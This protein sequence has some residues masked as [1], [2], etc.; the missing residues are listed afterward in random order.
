MDVEQWPEAGVLLIILV[1][2]VRQN[3]GALLASV[4]P[5]V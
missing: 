5:L 3:A 4:Q 2:S 1:A